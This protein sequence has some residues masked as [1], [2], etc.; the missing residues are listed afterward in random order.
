MN[1]DSQVLTR[2]TC[3]NS[4]VNISP[5]AESP[6]DAQPEVTAR[7]VRGFDA[8]QLRQSFRPGEID[9]RL[10]EP[11]PFDAHLLRLSAAKLVLTLFRYSLPV[12]L[13]GTWPQGYLALLFG[14][15]IPEGAVAHGQPFPTGAIA[16][17]DGS[18]GMDIRLPAHATCAIVIV[19]RESFDLA[20]SGCDPAAIYCGAENGISLRVR[21][22]E[23]RRLKG[24]LRA[25]LDDAELASQLLR[26]PAFSL[27]F[28]RDVL[29]SYAKALVTAERLHR[30]GFG[31]LDRRNRLVKKAE[32]YVIERLDQ[33]IHMEMLCRELGASPRALEYAF[34]ANYGM[35]AMRYLRTIRLNEV[36]NA[37]LHSGG[38][39]PATV[40]SIAMDWGFWHLGE[41]AAAY[42]RLFG[43]APSETL[44]MAAARYGGTDD[45]SVRETA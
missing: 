36:R 4:L 34:Q 24:L 20:M 37:L 22:P 15:E 7:V 10:L 5:P 19:D 29:R 21:E 31:V 41:F 11:G 23:A 27:V 39:N 1:Y 14:L 42:R 33:S 12:A 18:T 32:E 17:L 43:E 8:D 13:N 30:K 16:V 26:T 9:H 38:S 44:R 2:S 28:E 45:A 40:T 35:G 25:V 3:S 6:H